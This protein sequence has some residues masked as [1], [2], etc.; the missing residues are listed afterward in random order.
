MK[1]G[2]TFIASLPADDEVHRASDAAQQGFAPGILAPT[3]I[4]LAQPGIGAKRPE[5]ARLQALLAR[6]PGVAAVLGPPQQAPGAPPVTVARDGNAARYAVVLDEDPLGAPAV[7]RFRALRDDVPALVQ[8]AGLGPGVKLGFG[9]ETALADDTITRVLDDLKRVSVV[10][11]IVNVVLLVLFMRAFVAPLYLGRL[12]RARAAREPRADDASVPAGPRQRR[13]HVLRPVRRRRCCSSRSARTT[14][15]SSPGASGRRR[16]RYRLREA[17][18]VAM[19]AA[20][21]A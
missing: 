8:R 5:L 11:I 14:T 21:R 7:D 18:A 3:E 19:P 16:G 1:L 2:L 6:E 17:I 4:D 20:A 13:P 12:E 15:C 9:G 10:A